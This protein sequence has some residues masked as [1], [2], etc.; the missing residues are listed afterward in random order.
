MA[1]VALALS[2]AMSPTKR[3]TSQSAANRP[4]TARDDFGLARVVAA[5]LTLAGVFHGC[6]PADEDSVVEQ[7]VCATG[8]TVEGV[9]VSIYQGGH[10]DWNAVHASGRQFAITRINDGVNSMDPTFR[11]NWSGIRAAGMIRGA[12]QYFR[13][14][15]DAA[16]QAR[17]VCSAVGRLGDGDLPAM[18]DLESSGGMSS[19]TII[20]RIT[21]WLHDVEACTGKRPMIYTA[22]WFWNPNVGSRA[23]GAYPLV[24]AAYGPSCPTLPI[25]WTRWAIFQYSD[26]EV[27]Y[28][29]GVG[30]VP[31]IGQSCDRDKFNGSLA[32][33]R[34]FAGSDPAWGAQFVGQSFPYASVG[35]V[36]V[37]AGDS[38]AAWI[39]MRNIGSHAW[40]SNTRLATTE[41]RDRASRFAGRD[42]VATNRPEA[43]SGTVANGATFRFNFTFNAP[44]TLA[45]GLYHEHFG[46]VQ[47]GVSWFSA[48]G[49]AGPPDN[50]LEALVEVLPAII[51]PVIDAGV[52]RPDVHVVDASATD[53]Q[54]TDGRVADA[55]SS[56]GSADAGSSDASAPRDGASGDANAR[57][58]DG[59]DASDGETGPD[60]GP[61]GQTLGGCSVTRRNERTSLA[62]FMGGLL[63]IAVMR[64]RRRS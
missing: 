21:T 12:Y 28:T 24:V 43:V 11:T 48:A 40:N 34:N 58:A 55:Q 17:I 9:D 38:V 63:A 53:A 60:G 59:G 62:A 25:G 31:G 44:A 56:D 51:A 22:A 37:H 13:P 15:A 10:I 32:D 2:L 54:V 33:L 64:R 14:N 7:A 1:G 8:A 52:S 29:P 42:W 5:M 6:A 20:A 41:P 49:Q 35:P 46:M 4:A 47:E 18:L 30:P 27:R 26:G 16:T 39:T 36:R 45:P 50:Q 19:S 57:R 23:F 3:P 61:G